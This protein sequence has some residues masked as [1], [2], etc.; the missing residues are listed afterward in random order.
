MS[1]SSFDQA[2]VPRQGD[3]RE[4]VAELIDAHTDTVQLLLA[5]EGDELAASAHCDY[6]RALQRLGH[7][8]LARLN[9]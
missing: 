5:Q 9:D 6:L 4:L 2:T 7:E 3:L 8:T 1:G